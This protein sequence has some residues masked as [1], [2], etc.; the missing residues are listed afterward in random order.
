MIFII[1]YIYNLF[2]KFEKLLI[3]KTRCYNIHNV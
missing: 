3:F 2:D 1:D